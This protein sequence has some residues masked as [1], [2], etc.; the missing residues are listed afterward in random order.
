MS[1]RLII[2]N[3]AG[4]KHAELDLRPINIFIGEHATGKSVAAKLLYFIKDLPINRVFWISRGQSSGEF[5]KSATKDFS[6]YFS[7]TMSAAS[8]SRIRYY[9]DYPN[10]RKCIEIKIKHR[11]T[12]GVSIKFPTE[13]NHICALY[14]KDLKDLRRD[15]GI[16]SERQ[17]KRL[18]EKEDRLETRA[19]HDM[20]AAFKPAI[21]SYQQYFLPAVRSLYAMIETNPF[22][23]ISRGA[24]LDP[25]VVEFGR[26]YKRLKNDTIENDLWQVIPNFDE[27]LRGHYKRSQGSE[28]IEHTDGRTVKLRY[29]SSGQQELLPYMVVLADL[30]GKFPLPKSVYFEEPE[31][32]LFPSNQRQIVELAVL[33]YNKMVNG[34]QLTITTH[35]PYIL[36]SLD[37]LMQAGQLAKNDKVDK[38]ALAKVVK[39]ELWLDPKAVG[40]WIFEDG[41][42]H[43]IID[44][45]NGLIQAS[46]IDK[47]SEEIAV[48]FDKLLDL[49]FGE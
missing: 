17:G 15:N 3:F 1:E 45:E 29:L 28:Y 41:E 32:H 42:C 27:L 36:T 25:Y 24:D 48:Q 11:T 18:S 10:R 13:L 6:R 39:K 9:Y 34:M 30:L 22:E 2:E 14:D 16:E 47:T 35:S 7:Y 31:S 33:A 44:Q 8:D 12:D 20:F 49:E 40:A 4:I 38:T 5:L 19:F 26:I 46:K 37:N 23:L 43:S 21:I